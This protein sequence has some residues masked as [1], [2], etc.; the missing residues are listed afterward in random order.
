MCVCLCVCTCILAEGVSCGCLLLHVVS[1]QHA[2]DDA[3][4]MVRGMKWWSLS[5]RQA[6]APGPLKPTACMAL[7]LHLY[8]L[9]VHHCTHARVQSCG[10]GWPDLTRAHLAVGHGGEQR[11]EQRGRS[12]LCDEAVAR[13]ART[14]A[15]Q[16]DGPDAR[17]TRQP[18]IQAGSCMLMRCPASCLQSSA[19]SYLARMAAQML[20]FG[21]F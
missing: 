11:A 3:C 5:G 19:P 6:I 4:Y 9:K 13:L 17:R 15:A 18:C 20:F 7:G 16:H 12:P 2:A 8:A 14:H 10:G 21:L 1:C